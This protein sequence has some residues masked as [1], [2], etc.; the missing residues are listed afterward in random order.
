VLAVN[1]MI[2][3]LAS[4]ANRELLYPWPVWV[5]GP[6]AAALFATTVGVQLIR[7]DQ[8]EEPGRGAPEQPRRCRPEQPW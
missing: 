5:A 8:P 4:L 3:V 7:R 1:L 6:S 2:W